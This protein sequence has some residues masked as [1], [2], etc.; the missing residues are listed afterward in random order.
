[1][2]GEILVGSAAPTARIETRKKAADQ[3]K[4]L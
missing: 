3:P 4:R 1:M 2:A